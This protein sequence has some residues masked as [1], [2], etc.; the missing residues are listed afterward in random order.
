MDKQLHK[1]FSTSSQGRFGSTV[2]KADSRSS[3]SLPELS[4]ERLVKEYRK[5]N[6]LCYT[7]GDKF[8]PGHQARCPKRV[9]MQ[10]SALTDEEL[11]MT[12][13]EQTLTQIELEEKGEEENFRLSLNA[14][15]GT[16]NEECMAVRALLQNQVILV[17]VD[18]GSST[19]F[20]NKQLVDRMGLTVHPCASCKV[21]VANGEI[22]YSDTM[23]RSLEWWANGHTYQNDM[24]VLGLGAYDAILGYDWLRRHSPMHCDWEAKVISFV[25]KGIEVQLV[26]N[27]PQQQVVQEVSS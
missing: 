16:T 20:I 8:E 13:S 6:G 26:G 11:G 3:V 1:P 22:M 17:L 15:S 10:L 25:D 12:L 14:L 18:S 4:K 9:Q 5:Q 24:R 19:S 7:C 21:R 2:P 23:V 27:H